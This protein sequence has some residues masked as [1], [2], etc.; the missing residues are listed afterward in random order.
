MKCKRVTDESLHDLWIVFRKTMS[1]WLQIG[2]IRCRSTTVEIKSLVIMKKRY[3]Q[4]HIRNV[5]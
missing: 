2:F 4:I 1:W 3:V 5:L